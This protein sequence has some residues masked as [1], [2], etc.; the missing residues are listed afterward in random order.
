[1]QF[2]L[3]TTRAVYNLDARFVAMAFEPVAP[4][5]SSD[6]AL[7]LFLAVHPEDHPGVLATGVLSRRIYAA[8]Y[9]SYIGLRGNRDAAVDRAM[10]LF[11]K[12]WFMDK[13]T[14]RLL[15]IQ[16][17]HRGFAHYATRVLGPDEAFATM[18]YKIVY[19]NDRSG[20]DYGAWAFHGDLPVQKTAD[21]GQVLIASEWTR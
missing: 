15:R 8:T 6:V 1:M 17:S 9:K 21:D 3:K 5:Q 13:S 11:D 18:F 19:S 7:E 14:L 16:F 2:W 20:K 12:G 4:L 10:K